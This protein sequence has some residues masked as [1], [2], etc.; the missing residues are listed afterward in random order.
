MAAPHRERVRAGKPERWITCAFRVG[1]TRIAQ[2]PFIDDG[3]EM[4][5]RPSTV[6]TE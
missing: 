1:S 6:A 3:N 4:A 2:K 5:D